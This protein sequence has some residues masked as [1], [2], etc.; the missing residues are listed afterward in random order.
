[1]S[2][3]LPKRFLH[4]SRARFRV[5]CTIEA[6]RE[7]KLLII[8]ERLVAEH[9][10][11]VLVHPGPDLVERPAIGDSAQIDR[12]HLGG[13]MRMKLAERQGHGPILLHAGTRRPPCVFPMYISLMTEAGNIIAELTRRILRDLGDPQTLNSAV[14]ERWRTPLW[15]ALE[16]SALT[17]AWVPE[18]LNGAGAR[19]ADGFEIL[20]IAGE[21]ALAVPLAETLL[22]G[23]LLSRTGLPVPH[24]MLSIAPV[25]D[26][27]RL[28]VG[29]DG[30]LS[31][32]P[33]RC[34][35]H[36]MPSTSQSLRGGARKR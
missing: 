9:E 23:W 33:L 14:D 8:G 31:D 17:K 6:L 35:S 16:D 20:R 28:Q 12:A 4:D 25:R 19:I 21:F 29:A 11:C 27:E 15:R 5:Q 30:K 36:A 1:M 24:G 3:S 2:A 18:P 26:G 7:R 32:S 10:D 22:A 13:E 34:P